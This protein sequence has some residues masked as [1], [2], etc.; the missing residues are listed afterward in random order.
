ML[1]ADR[2]T[3]GRWGDVLSGKLFR[4]H[5][6][7]SR[8]VR[9]YH[10]RL[11]V[12]H[13]S[14][15]REDLER[16]DELPCVLLRTVYLEREDRTG[17]LWEVLLIEFVVRMAFE[18]WMADALYLRMVSEEVDYLERI[19]NVTLYAEWQR[20]NALKQNPCVEW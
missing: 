12:C 16:V 18:R 11:D 15:Q 10:E 4:S 19:L 13:V 17:T 14:Q 7:V 5:L 2:E 9:V 20:L 3:D 6:R 8:G 1:Y